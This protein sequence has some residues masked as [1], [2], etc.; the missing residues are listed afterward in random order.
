VTAGGW[1]RPAYIGV[2]S[3]LDEPVSR[4]CEARAALRELPQSTSF[5]DSGLYRS[6][7]LG[8]ADQPDFVNAVTAFMT[9]LDGHALLGRLQALEH[10]RGRTR[11]G[12]HWGPR[13]LDL[14]LLVLGNVILDEPDLRIPHPRIH[15]RNFVL[16]PLAEIAPHMRVPGRGSVL[17]LLAAV[18]DSKPRIERLERF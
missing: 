11:A 15:E 17:R 5:V 7:P 13:T 12:E 4:V 10:A 2:G 6:E 1:W 14:D 3:N 8:P 9:G 18:A 16:L